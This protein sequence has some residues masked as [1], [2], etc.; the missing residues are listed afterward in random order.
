VQPRHSRALGGRMHEYGVKECYLGTVVVL[1]VGTESALCWSVVVY[2]FDKLQQ[3]YR[4]H[5]A[6]K[7]VARVRATAER[8]IRENYY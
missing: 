8:V 1:I 2:R 3:M 7:E 4:Q 6:G 5:G